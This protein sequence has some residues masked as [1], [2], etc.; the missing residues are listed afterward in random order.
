[1][2]TENQEL[3]G[4]LSTHRITVKRDLVGRAI[5]GVS[6][7]HGFGPMLV[8]KLG[9]DRWAA[10]GVHAYD[11]DYEWDKSISLS[12]IQVSECVRPLYDLKLVTYQEY[13]TW[14][15][16]VDELDRIKERMEK[17]KEID[18]LI[19]LATRYPEVIRKMREQE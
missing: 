9:N 15:E 17:D 1:M 3:L 18:K 7:S 13:V 4:R 2:K 16:E 14:K 8:L 10:I 11:D 5:T 19:E 12:T 6:D